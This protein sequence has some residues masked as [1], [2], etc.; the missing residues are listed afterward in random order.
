MSSGTPSRRL[1]DGVDAPAVLAGVDDVIALYERWGGIHYDDRVSQLDH[2]LQCASLAEQAGA[3]PHLVA[4]ALLHDI[5]HL[6]EL[7]RSDG[8]IGDLAV[9]RGHEHVAVRAL[10][11]VFGPEVLV[12]IQ[13]HVE[14]KRYLCAVEPGY[15]ATLSDGSVRSLATQGGPMS[16]DEVARFESRPEASDAADVRRWD[17]A[18]KVE[19]LGVAPLRHFVP[20]LRSLATAAN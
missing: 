8:T 17:D 7:A 10:A 4:A 11:G 6:L 5:G 19:H 3:A 20:L 15:T 12:P 13:L 18:G 16:A 2:A 9:D 14:A 1:S